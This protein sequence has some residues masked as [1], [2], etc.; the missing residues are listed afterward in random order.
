MQL[1]E[2]AAKNETNAKTS[3]YDTKKAPN[4]L[5][6]QQFNCICAVCNK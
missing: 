6:N 1:E 4:G 3:I 5:I 2:E